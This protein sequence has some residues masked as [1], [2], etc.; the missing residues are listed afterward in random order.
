MNDASVVP[1]PEKPVDWSM[2]PRVCIGWQIGMQHGWGVHGYHL[3]R[4]LLERRM[5]V[6]STN[7]D[8]PPPDAFPTFPCPIEDY[9]PGQPMVRAGHNQPFEPGLVGRRD[10]LIQVHEDFALLSR[11]VQYLHAFDERVITVSK[12]NADHLKASGI[13]AKC[14][15]LGVDTEMFRPRPKATTFGADRFVI[16]SGGKAELRKGQDI[17][18]AA[19]KAF[20]QRHPDALL[21]TMWH[22]FWPDTMRGL[23]LSPHNCGLPEVALDANM[24]P[25][26]APFAIQKWVQAYGIPDNAH[27]ELG[28]MGRSALADLFASVDVGLFPNRCE[29]GTNMVAMEAMASGV[30]C[31]LSN[32]SG[33]RDLI[34]HPIPCYKLDENKACDLP[35]SNIMWGEARVEEIV[36]GLEHLYEHRGEARNT[37]LLAHEAMKGYWSWNERMDAQIDALELGKV[38]DAREQVRR[39]IKAAEPPEGKK[40]VRINPAARELSSQGFRLAEAGFLQAGYTSARKALAMNQD[41]PVLIGN[42]GNLAMRMLKTADAIKYSE[43]ALKAG[44]ERSIELKLRHNLGLAY[45]YAGQYKSAIQELRKCASEYPTGAFDLACILM[46]DGQWKEGFELMEI[47]R[48]MYP[49]YHPKYD[50]PEWDGKPLPDGTLWVTVEQGFGDIFMLTRFLPWAKTQCKKLIVSTNHETMPMVYGY[51]GVDEFVLWAFGMPIP[52]ADAHV[53]ILTLANYYG[54]TPENLPADPGHFHEHLEGVTASSKVPPTMLRVGL[55]WQGSS[56]HPRDRE[57]SIPFGELLPLLAIPNVVFFSFQKGPNAND[58]KMFGADHLMVDSTASMGNWLATAAALKQMD[59]LISV[60]TAVCHLAGCL[61]VPTWAML[62]KFPDWRWLKSGDTTKWYPSLRLLRQKKLG[63]WAGL[64]EDTHE[65]L[66]KHA[67]R[68]IAERT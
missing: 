61:G 56:A 4:R 47:R 20:Q 53:P 31:I 39:M 19:F 12:W 49:E 52:K 8:V 46:L 64:I 42:M 57:R 14:V 55:C 68:V 33:H 34:E 6:P 51:P 25:V 15:H 3:A 59:L 21:V 62:C 18:L 58:I 13:P 66:R 60:D 27:H 38:G 40:L 5:A 54:A 26:L 32:N 24:K 9:V 30:P 37:G 35:G 16:F 1:L 65:R 22:N 50:M 41:D 29:G 17:V 45:A 48:M 43:Q 7:F 28:M 23:A 63:D 36:E 2:L 11:D 44:L 10:G 67:D